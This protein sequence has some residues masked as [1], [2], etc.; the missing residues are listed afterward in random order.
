M[1]GD[2]R[3]LAEG[4]DALAKE[5]L[6]ARLA[7]TDS[8]EALRLALEASEAG[9]PMGAVIASEIAAGV[10]NHAAEGLM[11]LDAFEQRHGPN[12]LLARYR[13]HYLTIHTLTEQEIR[14]QPNLLEENEA[15]GRMPPPP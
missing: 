15:R 4:G 9:R 7:L 10:D 8:N 5:L 13:K 2:L 14:S 12:P 11:Y 1:E 6:A 3:R